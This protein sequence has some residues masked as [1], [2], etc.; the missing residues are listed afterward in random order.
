MSVTGRVV[1]L[2]IAAV[3]F[4]I[5]VVLVFIPGPAIVFFVIA[6]S[7]LAAE[8]L[9]LAKTLDHLEIWI[10]LALRWARRFWHRLSLVGKVVVGLVTAACGAGFTYLSW[11][12][13][14]G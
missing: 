14:F 12:M 8:S 6:G 3:A 2:M 10:R 9:M 1:R 11:R 5:G 4:V 7:L 13:M